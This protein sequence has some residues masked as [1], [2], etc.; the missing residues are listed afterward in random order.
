ME[1]TPLAPKPPCP[2]PKPAP[3]LLPPSPTPEPPP[4]KAGATL[5]T[6]IAVR[7][8][9]RRGSVHRNAARSLAANGGVGADGARDGEE[10]RRC[11]EASLVPGGKPA[12]MRAGALKEGVNAER[13]VTVGAFV[14]ERPLSSFYLS[15]S[16]GDIGFTYTSG[17]GFQE[18]KPDLRRRRPTTN[19]AP[20]GCHEKVV[21]VAKK[22]AGAFR[23]PPFPFPT[24]CRSRWPVCYPY[25]PSSKRHNPFGS[26]GEGFLVPVDGARR[27][28]SPCCAPLA[29][30]APFS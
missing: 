10:R 28:R 9:P 18:D 7:V 16:R 5:A 11:P 21:R 27:V 26:P 25:G 2:W 20:P 13:R 6:N 22:G 4:A 30:H 3:K 8:G 14:L 17:R 12:R 15:P 23:P 24:P 19:R 29:R 1:Q